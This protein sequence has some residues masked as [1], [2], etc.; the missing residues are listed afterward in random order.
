MNAM[1]TTI[2]LFAVGLCCTSLGSVAACFGSYGGEG[3]RGGAMAAK[4][5][6][7]FEL[8]VR[9]DA[10]AVYVRSHGL[11]RD[12]SSTMARVSIGGTGHRHSIELKPTAE[13]LEGAGTF[14]FKPGRR[15][16]LILT[17]PAAPPTVVH[18]VL[19]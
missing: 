18:F 3:P 16:T 5:H 10:V 4:G 14:R 12:V 7:Q 19:R 15:A 17:R 1:N 13:G 9:P 11:P 2:S 6:D 8:V